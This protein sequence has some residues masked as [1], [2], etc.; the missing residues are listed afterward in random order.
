[1]RPP[2]A[3]AVRDAS[4]TGA[5]AQ[6][7]EHLTFNQVVA[8]SNPARPTIYNAASGRPQAKRSHN[9]A[10]NAST[11]GCQLG[12]AVWAVVDV[13]VRIIKGPQCAPLVLVLAISGS[14]PDSRLAALETSASNAAQRVRTLPVIGCDVSSLILT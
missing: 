2:A 9:V 4:S 1:M 13:N 3:R 8:G 6:L 5:L 10:A 12:K 14:P 7:V 11:S